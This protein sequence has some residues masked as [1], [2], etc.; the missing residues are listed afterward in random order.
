MRLFVIP[1]YENFER[2]FMLSEKELTRYQRHLLLSN[3]GL[4]G[5]KKLRNAHVTIIGA[6][7]L[8]SPAALYLTAAGVG[9]LRLIDGDDVDISNLQRQILYK[10]NHVGAAKV[11]SAQKTLNALNTHV[12]VEP[13]CTYITNKNVDSLLDGTHIVLDCCDSFSTRLL[14]NQACWERG[15]PLI[16]GAGI[17]FEGQIISID[18]NQN[19]PCYQCLFPE[20]AEPP[21]MNC[22]SVGVLGPVLGVVGSLQALEAIK[23]LVGLEVSSL[24]VLRMFDATSLQWMAM[25]VTKRTNCP[26]CNA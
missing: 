4:E 13:K 25:S 14:I 21:T 12:S 26:V 8:G 3:I 2:K 9:S 24:G 18:P 19:T 15:I 20:N 10:A 23:F 7:G 17:R 6:G 11:D 1:F 16:S 5:Q 22:S